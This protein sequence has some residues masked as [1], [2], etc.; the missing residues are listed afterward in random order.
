MPKRLLCDLLMV[1]RIN[2][3]LLKPPA[4]VREA[5][6]L[7]EGDTALHLVRVRSKDGAPFGYYASWSAGLAKP[8]NKRDFERAPRLEIFRKQG[9][10]ISHVTQT[11]SAIAATEDLAK[12]LD[13]DVGAPLISLVRHSFDMQGGQE[14]MVD[15]LQVYYHPDRFQYRMDLQ[16]DGAG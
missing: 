4:A 7:G 16:V 2:D 9:L 15:Y 14:R 1:E 3:D 11:I 10:A 5:L 6:G 12:H 8:V 13:T